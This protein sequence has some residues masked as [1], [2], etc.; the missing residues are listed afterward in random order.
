MKDIPASGTLSVADRVKELRRQ[1]ADIASFSNRPAVPEAVIAAAKTALDE[2]WSSAYTDS[3]G[4]PELRQ[5]IARQLASECGFEADPEDE[6]MVTAGGKEGIF[7]ALFA[8]VNPGDE[9]VIP[10]PSWVTYDPCVGFAGGIPVAVPS[11]V[12]NDF[13]PDP[14]AIEA[15]VTAKTK[16][17]VLT[18]PHNPTGAV[19]KRDT[20]EAIAEIAK[21]HQL[22]V[23][24]DECYR[25]YLY[26]NHQ[27]FSIA[28]L[29]GMAER[30][31]TVQTTSKIF[32]MFGWRVGWIAGP[33]D[34]MAEMLKIH[35]HVVACAN[36]VAQAGAIAAINLD[37]EY[38]RTTVRTYEEARDTLLKELADIPAITA[39]VPEG[40][41]FLFPDIRGLG[42]DSEEASRFLL[43]EA[44]VMTVPGSA[45]GSNGEGHVRLLFSCTA[46]EAA[47][48]AGRIRDAVARL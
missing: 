24:S 5:A 2:A 22:L 47:R 12:E 10:D 16:M 43:E 20:L 21:R 37:P 39:H 3:A 42:K 29:P 32:N 31:L 11:P 48:V 46:E 30:T 41:Y 14:E 38:I 25:H 17:I 15:A 33:S 40:G 35:Q 9:V 36:A 45:F 18:T 27:H 19:L 44:R 28:S 26:D 13:H 23:L 4:L 34:I 7:A 1:G 8:T 6:I